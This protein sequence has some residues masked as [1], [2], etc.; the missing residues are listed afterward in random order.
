MSTEKE[1]FIRKYSETVYRLAYSKTGNRCDADEIYQEVFLRY[2]KRN[3]KFKDSEHEKAW[4]LRVTVNVCK[5][6]FNS[7][8]CRR[9]E[10]LTDDIEFVQSEHIDLPRELT[11]LPPIYREVIHLFYYEELSIKEIASLT[12]RRE[13]TVRT[14][15]TRAREKV[16]GS[17]K[18]EDY[19]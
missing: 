3:P 5:K 4:I 9:T 2:I 12:G 1:S 16:R 18:E 19:V 6:Y 13:S 10:A 8:W 14:Q 15:L 11:A 17:M 7:P